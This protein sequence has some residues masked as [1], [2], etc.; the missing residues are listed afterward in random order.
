MRATYLYKDPITNLILYKKVVGDTVEYYVFLEKG[1]LDDLQ[2]KGIPVYSELKAYTRDGQI[3][4]PS[5]TSSIIIKQGVNQSRSLLIP[6]VKFKMQSGVDESALEGF[7]GMFEYLKNAGYVGTYSK[8]S[9]KGSRFK[10]KGFYEPKGDYKLVMS[11]DNGLLFYAEKGAANKIGFS[12]AISQ[13]IE[14]IDYSRFK[15]F[16]VRM[17]GIPFSYFGKIAE[18]TYYFM[19]TPAEQY[20]YLQT[21]IDYNDYDDYRTKIEMFAQD[22]CDLSKEYYPTKSTPAAVGNEKEAIQEQI[23]ATK[24]ALQY[25][26]GMTEEE[27]SNLNE[28]LNS[29]ELTLKYI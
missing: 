14:K 7:M 10:K 25:S 23:E 28:Y 27:V 3:I 20:F 6:Y 19:Y 21:S 1:V 18:E 22:V 5:K 17:M 4:D 8:A 29:L 12:V 13:D 24:L 26:Q 15:D 2:K 11:C 16:K 9:Y